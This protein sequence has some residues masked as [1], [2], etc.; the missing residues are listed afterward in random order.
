MPIIPT[1]P[2]PLFQSGQDRQL[3][4]FFATHLQFSLALKCFGTYHNHRW[5]SIILMKKKKKKNRDKGHLH[6]SLSLILNLSRKTDSVSLSL[7]LTQ[8]SNRL[9]LFLSLSL[10]PIL[11]LSMF[12]CFDFRGMGFSK[13]KKISGEPLNVFFF[14]L[15][16]FKFQNL[17]KKKGAKTMSFWLN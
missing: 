10:K 15:I 9:G 3:G 5:S 16:F 7:N 12:L 2:T 17:F 14:F 4:G 13:K 1:T 6:L 11:P 8:L